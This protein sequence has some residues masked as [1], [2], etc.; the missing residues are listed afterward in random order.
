MLTFTV[1]CGIVTLLSFALQLT[2]LPPKYKKYVTH[3]M[4][5]FLGIT[6]GLLANFASAVNVALPEKLTVHQIRGLI[7]TFGSGILIFVLMLMSVL[8]EN[9]KQRIDAQKCASAVSG[10]FIL[11][12]MFASF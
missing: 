2:S 3:A 4:V 11:Y 9:D 5:L 12:L 1:V 7:I 6:I 8:I 10:F